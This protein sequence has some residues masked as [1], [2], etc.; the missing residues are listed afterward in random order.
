MIETGKFL[1]GD[2]MGLGKTGQTICTTE[3]INQWPILIITPANVKYNW[4]KEWKK[5][6]KKRKVTVIESSKE[7]NWNADVV[8]INYD[9]L[10]RKNKETGKVGLYFEE[11]KKDWKVIVGD[12]SQYLK[13]TK[14]IRTKMFKKL[15]KNVEY[16][17]LLSGT[18]IMNR[19]IEL[20]SQLQILG[21]FEELFGTWY[22]FVYRYCNAHKTRFGLDTSGASNTVELHK[23]LEKTC[24]IRREKRDVLDELPER[25]EILLNFPITNA[26]EYKLAEG[27]L[28][29]YLLKISKEK[30]IAAQNAEHL[31]LLNTLRQLTVKGK[32][33]EVENWIEEFLE[34]SQEKLMVVGNFKKPLEY[35][36]KKFKSE[37]ITGGVSSKEKLKIIERFKTNKKRI[38]FGNI[39]SIGTGT[40]GL[41]DSASTM[42]IIDLPNRWT[43]IEQLIGRLERIGQLNK[44]MIYFG[45]DMD[46][47]DGKIWTLLQQKKFITDVVNK[48]QINM[49]ETEQSLLKELL[50][51]YL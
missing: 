29:Q 42:L 8:I 2:D 35:L 28:I 11:L 38:I 44:I 32:L 51:S 3:T 5:W 34:S 31:V 14:A 39:Q 41:Q 21:N 30:A 12:E 43:D 45:L 20:V 18:M 50:Q 27:N 49:V 10:G 19:P 40:D 36:H 26:Q 1:N 46:T 24:Y 9:I 48:G 33:K 16:R 4:E 7:N 15:S 22:R 47:I 17:Y 13:N 6:T 25:Q 37:L 23:I